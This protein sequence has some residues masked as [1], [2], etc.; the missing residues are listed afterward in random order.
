VISESEDPAPEPGSPE[1]ELGS[2]PEEPAA[3]GSRET[4]RFPRER[5][6][7]PDR[8][9]KEFAVPPAREFTGTGNALIGTVEVRSP[10]VVRWRSRGRFGL[11][12]G[13]EAFPIIA[14]SRSGQL[15]VPPFRF[16]LV[17][18]IAS[19]R[20]TITVTPQG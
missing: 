7:D 9:G 10:V 3:P 15:V 4:T 18:V 1:P 17:R 12:F 16:E 20:W 2:E 14:P 11:E 8:R 13:R 6:E 5:S 19:G